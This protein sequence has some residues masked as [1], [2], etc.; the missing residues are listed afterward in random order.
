MDNNLKKFITNQ[1]D[2]QINQYDL[3]LNTIMQKMK[4]QKIFEK[5]HFFI[6]IKNNKFF[7]LFPSGDTRKKII[8]NNVK[9]V[10]ENLK[11]SNQLKSLPDMYLPFYISD[12]HYYHDND[13]PYF[14]EAKPKNQ[15]GIL[16][17]DSNYYSIKVDNET[18]NY[19]KFKKI[20]KK[21][22]CTNTNK[23]GENKKPIIFFSGANT[24]DDKHNIR[25]KLKNIVSEKKDKRYDI[26][27]SEEYYP[28]YYF[29]NFKYLLNLPGNQPWSYRMSKILLMGS[30]VIDI[31]MKQT[32]YNTQS[33]K[34]YPPND[35][36]IQIYSE[37]FKKD[38]DYIEIDYDWKESHTKNTQVI[39][40]YNNINTIYNNFQQN[41]NQYK[42]IVNSAT[43][44][45]NLL[46][47]KVFDKTMTY[48]IL[49]FTEKLYKQNTKEEINTFIDYLFT[50]EKKPILGKKK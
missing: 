28:M 12:T 8:I 30:L 5:M 7:V 41:D 2:F 29:C 48:L 6:I 21:H 37:F 3:S 26:K 1:S 40:I 22:K 10:L 24:G 20:I 39:N 19:D 47:M 46:N 33:K 16:F 13:I 14:I 18:I 32:F 38:E 35:K 34:F 9:N 15:K 43:K 36:W 11:S 25:M 27:I 31:N 49:K 42:M 4:K 50:L 45:A 17:P 44:K 23:V